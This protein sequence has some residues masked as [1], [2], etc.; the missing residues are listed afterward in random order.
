MNI[1]KLSYYI[2]FLILLSNNL[3]ASSDNLGAELHLYTVLPFLG[4][5]LSIAI[6]PLLYPIFWHHNYGKVSAFWS[7]LFLLPFAIYNGIHIT[8]Y[9][10]LHVALL[11][12]FPFII[13]LFSLFTIS[14]GIHIG[15]NFSG[16]PQSNVLILLSGTILASWM[17]TTGASMLLIRP[18]LRAN[19]WRKY[20]VHTVIFFIFLVA[21]IGGAL[22]PLGDPP[23]FLGFLQGVSFF[24]TAKHLFFPMLI[25][26]L[27]LLVIYYFLDNYYYK[28]ENV[29][30]N[31]YKGSEPL[32][33][34]GKINIILI[35][36][37]ISAVLMSGIWRP[38]YNIHVYGIYLELQNI[39]RDCILLMLAFISWKSTH[40][41][42]RNKNDFTWFPIKEVGKLFAGIFITIIPAI[43]RI[44]QSI[45]N[46]GIF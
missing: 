24:W 11:E 26:S 36:C 28:R 35:L 19:R 21:N 5:L 33:V 1:N 23:L 9:Y 27:I 10:F 46:H 12:Y 38:L 4:L 44:S 31:E 16:T 41:D 45:F 14:G 8:L 42:I 25:I 29:N 39:V 32:S 40:V 15:R 13:L 43:N 17:G 30:K 3:Y 7:M 20:S 6:M 34:H 2:L 22:T 18:L 37:S